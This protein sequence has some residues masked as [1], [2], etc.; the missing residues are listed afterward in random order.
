VIEPAAFHVPLVS[1]V[2]FHSPPEVFESSTVYIV[3]IP[4]TAGLVSR[5]VKP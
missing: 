2:Y 3:S 5:N 4:G 1:S